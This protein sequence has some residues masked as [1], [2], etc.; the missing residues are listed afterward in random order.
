MSSGERLPP[1]TSASGGPRGRP[2][3]WSQLWLALAVLAVVA[4]LAGWN[5]RLAFERQHEQAAERLQALAELRGAQVEGW[6]QRQL[7]LASFLAGSGPLAELYLQWQQ[8]GDTEAG[9]RL[10]SRSIEFRRAAD[11]DSVMLMAAD[12]EV[13]AREHEQAPEPLAEDAELAQAARRAVDS[14]LPAQAGIRQIP[15]G[16]YAEE[17]DIVV[18][19]RLSGSPPRGLVVW[20]VDVERAL[21]PLLARSALQG[22]GGETRLWRR[23]DELMV[24]QGAAPA[25][26]RPGASAAGPRSLPWAASQLPL[27]QVLRGGA[28]AN[29]VFEADDE[30]GTAVLATVRPVEGTDWWLVVTQARSEVDAPAWALARWTLAAVLLGLAACALGLRLWVQ[31]QTLLLAQRERHEHQERVKALGLLE[32]IAQSSS[33][34]IFAKDTQGRY[35]F[36][37][38][39]ACEG[40]GRAREDVLGRTD[41]ELFGP[42]VAARITA[43]DAQALALP[44][45]RVY[46]ETIPG[47]QGERVKLST[48]GALH[49]AEGRLLGVFGV[50]RDVT[51]SRRAERALRDSEAHYRSVVSVLSEGVFVVD[52]AGKVLSCNPAAEAIIGSS[53]MDWQG[54]GAIAPGWEVLDADG[55]PLPPEAT[56]PMRVLRDG[57]P[58]IDEVLRTRDRAG[59]ERWFELSAQPVTSP[60]D[61]QRI[62]AVCSFWEV[63]QDKQQ[64]DELA[65]HRHHLEELVAERTREVRAVSESLADATRFIRTIADA[66]P[67]RLSYWDAERRCRYVNRSWL[68]W[69]GLTLE[70]ALGHGI[71]ELLGDDYARAQAP[72]VDA[73]MAGQAQHF[74]LE[75]ERQ[76]ERITHQVHYIPDQPEGDAVRGIYVIAFDISAAKRAERQ[77]RLANTELA[78]ARDRAETANRAKSAFLANMSHEIRT[79]M[80]AILGLTHLMARESRDTLQRDRLQKVDHAAQHLLQVINDILDLSKIEAGKLTLEDAEFALDELM[81]R[82]FELVSAR[83]ADKGLELV[84]DTD[85]LPQR[86]RGDPTRLSQALINLLTNAVKFTARGWVRLRGE[87]LGEDPHGL[88]VRFEVQDTGTGIALEQQALL[89][90]AFEQADSSSTRLHGGTGLGLALTRHIAH[91]MGGEVGVDSTPG[92][93]SSF[94]F[95]ARLGHAAEA[96]PQPA[97]VALRGLRVLLVDDLAEARSALTDR[98]QLLGMAVDALADGPT[99]LAHVQAEMKAGRPYDVL[100]LDWR[101]APLDGV[102]T[103]RGLRQL[104]GDGTPPSV[105]VTAFDEPAMWQQARAAGC[106][107]V[108]IKPITASALHDTL[109]RVLQQQGVALAMPVVPGVAEQRLRRLHAGQRVLLAEDNAI[110]QEVAGELLRAVGLVVESAEDGQTA[111]QMAMSRPYD[112]ILMDVQMPVMD[113]MTATR[114]LRRRAGRGLP[115]VAMTAHA[116]GEDRAACLDAGMNDHVA[117]PVDPEKLY[118]TLLRWLPLPGR[119]SAT[120]AQALPPQATQPLLERLHGVPGLDVD[121]A[122]RHVGGQPGTLARVLARFID[123]YREGAPALAV[124]GQADD[125]ARWRQASHSL[126]GA[127]GAIGA[128]GLQQAAQK[129]EHDIRDGVPAP[130]LAPMALA[131][132][133]A[134]LGFAQRLA[135]A[136]DEP[137]RLQ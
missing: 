102:E 28:A 124:H 81:T 96:A 10:L 125:L 118:A 113:G 20:R 130:D 94:W 60:T 77:L 72:R 7:G 104:L 57:Q 52:P 12:G 92:Q 62:A 51:E 22:R 129:L 5:I 103:L 76:G 98:L 26:H 95:T 29:T 14:G 36:Y 40:I 116:F 25:G 56:P 114:E 67:G 32:A 55:Q 74:E 135:A 1:S 46:E 119:E 65:R 66:L 21:L 61:G 133:E 112:L 64:Q 69:H 87:L 134:L 110:N 4:P 42:E 54:Q 59:R 3:W 43:N 109:A 44:A 16:R 108:L 47:P 9:A 53:Q 35:V 85:H 115:V 132:H 27:A 49:D 71:H 93:G 13:L 68:A 73:A 31:Q 111:V 17:L 41:E 126:R 136:L 105:L 78:L 33:D 117:K 45:P 99:A 30:F 89:F 121:L 63:T 127:C 11:V 91:L 34:A 120:P 137:A 75:A 15:G 82:C 128:A 90:N 37:N 101:M 8:R 19:L 100:L 58:V 79:P 88:M 131:L 106:D 23:V 122:L 2:R 97:P 84:L 80:N 86:L 38:R 83:A 39:A 24:A 107:A 70:Q 50:A 18:P 6:A 48:K 123:T